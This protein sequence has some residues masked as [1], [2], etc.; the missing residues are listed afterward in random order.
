MGMLLSFSRMIDALNVRLGKLVAW[1]VLA[2][3]ALSAGNAVVRK[4]FNWSTNGMLEMQWYL[5]GVV[6]MIGASWT[7]RDNEHVRVDV[8]SSRL[9]KFVR[10]R[11]EIFGLIFFFFPFALVHLYYSYSFFKVSFVTQE[12]STNAGGLIIWPAKFMVLLGFFLISLQGVS[13][14]IKRIAIV[15]G[16]LEEVDDMMAAKSETAPEVA[17]SGTRH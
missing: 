10:D 1:L 13:Q 8:I 6:F 9:S 14:L 5:F 17:G 11:I 16:D 12:W 2:A 3:V 7:M 15:R 4:V